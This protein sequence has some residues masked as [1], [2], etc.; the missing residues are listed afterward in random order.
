MLTNMFQAQ[1]HVLMAAAGDGGGGGGGGGTG[2]GGGAG[3]GDGDGKGGGK[4]SDGAGEGGG[5]DEVPESVRKYIGGAINAA[6]TNHGKRLETRLG[7]TLKT[8]LAEALKAFK[9]AGDET[10]GAGGQ[11]GGNGGGSGGGQGGK[12]DDNANNPLALEVKKL[13][14]D[15]E[16]QT[17]ARAAEAE[18]AQKERDLRARGEEKAALSQALRAAGVAEGRTVGAMALLFHEKSLVVRNEAGEICLKTKK[19]YQGETV[20]EILPLAEGVAV[21]AKSDEGKEYMAAVDAGGSGNRGGKRPDGKGSAKPTLDDA[22]AFVMT[23]MS[24]R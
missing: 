1:R 22:Y 19:V 4:G 7:D 21:W 10:G 12:G 15:L 2:K 3:G 11:G 8:S 20:E 13:K 18:Q 14:D 23:D 5:D 16:K 24:R 9:P 6:M 17:R